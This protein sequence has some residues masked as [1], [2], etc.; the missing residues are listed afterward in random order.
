VVTRQVGR[1]GSVPP[2]GGQPIP[3]ARA[4][5][6]L[7]FIPREGGRSPGTGKAAA[8]RPFPAY[9]GNPPLAP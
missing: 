9:G 2:H 5:E 7:G 8:T 1:K 6:A 3:L 4:R